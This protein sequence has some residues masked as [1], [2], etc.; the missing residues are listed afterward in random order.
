MRL[1][2]TQSFNR[3]SYVWN[4]P[5]KNSDPSGEIMLTGGYNYTNNT[6]YNYN[7]WQY[8]SA[9]TIAAPTWQGTDFGAMAGSIQGQLYAT[10]VGVSNYMATQMYSPPSSDP[11]TV[12]LHII[13]WGDFDSEIFYTA[14]VIKSEAPPLEPTNW[15]GFSDLGNFIFENTQWLRDIQTNASN[16]ASNVGAG[17]TKAS[18]QAHAM[19]KP[20]IDSQVAVLKDLYTIQA[21]LGGSGFATGLRNGVT[22]LRKVNAKALAEGWQGKGLYT[23]VDNWRNITLHKGKYVVGGLPG[24]SNYYTT[25]RGL[26]RSNLNRGSLFRGLQV[27]KHPEFGYRQ[28]VGVYKLNSNSSAAFGTTYANPQFGSGGLPQ[29]FIPDYSN[30]ELIKTIHLK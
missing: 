19:T 20:Y 25:L 17:M 2:N 18:Q 14:D 1:E 21:H 22:A 28:K 26:N 27:R 30:L 23:G 15:S 5:L 7:Q 6:N 16:W 29:I 3:Y 11:I 9:P 10:G 13:A 24:Q 12:S 8:Q 4:N